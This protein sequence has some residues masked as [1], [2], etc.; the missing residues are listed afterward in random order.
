MGEKHTASRK[1]GKEA[2]S[3]FRGVC[4]LYDLADHEAET[5]ARACQQLDHAIRAG[6]EVE[7]DGV[8]TTDRFGQTREHPALASERQC[9]N[10]YRL[11]M[12]EL[13]LDGAGTTDDHA[14]LYPR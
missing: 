10:S 4:K 12:R 2:K 13:R 3:V 9:L 14:R 7:R 6:R 1:W 8:S 11:L 5:L